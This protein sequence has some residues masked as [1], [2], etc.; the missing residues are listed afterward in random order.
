MKLL[1][2][3]PP[4]I[5][6][7]DGLAHGLLEYIDPINDTADPA[8]L[9]PLF[10][11]ALYGPHASAFDDDQWHSSHQSLGDGHRAGLADREVG[12]ALIIN[13][14]FFAITEHELSVRRLQL[15]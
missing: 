8:L 5:A 2:G 10:I 1:L 3:I 14:R 9:N 13:R 12:Q 7:R 15:A 4:V 6:R 11:P